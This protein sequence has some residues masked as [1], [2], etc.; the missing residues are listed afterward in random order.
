MNVFTLSWRNMWRN[1][2][3]TLITIA[4]VS[5]A[6]FFA[7]IMRAFQEG[8]YDRAI[9]NYVHS[10]SGHVQIHA[11]GYWDEQILEHSFVMNDSLLSVIEAIPEVEKIIPRLHSFT[12][13]S[14]EYLTKAALVMGVNPEQDDMQSNISNN[15]IF[16]SFVSASDTAVLVSEGLAEYLT[17]VR[18]D[19][20]FSE[21]KNGT[22][23]L[24]SLRMVKD[25][26]VLI[27]QGMYGYST[28]GVYPVQGI[29]SYP[30][31]EMNSQVI[32]MPLQLAQNFFLA[33]NRVTSISLI[34]S[35][36]EHLNRIQQYLQ[37]TLDMDVYEVMSW[38]EMNIE[39]VQ[40]IETDRAGGY[41]M[42]F[43]L[44]LIIGFGIFGTVVMMT[45]ERKR[46]FGIIVALGMRKTRLMYRFCV[47]MVYMGLIGVV[48]GCISAL[49]VLLY[50]YY[51]P[52]RFSGEL[53]QMMK[54]YGFEP[55][56]PV[57]FDMSLFVDHG[58]IVLVLFFV[59]ALYTLG[60]IRKLEVIQAIR[61]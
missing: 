4:S 35:D 30:D 33:Q 23:T 45:A 7:L 52:V 36:K 42:I 5:S 27:S 43:I 20:T 57:S 48:G 22:D 40:Q 44:Y 55:I 8:T 12:F 32:Y 50:F 61:N 28:N 60:T 18:R 10:F 54:N 34:L 26:I 19:T 47:E 59:S 16:G 29:I 13:A 15:V 46:E 51:N 31:P 41:V 2:R 14:S 6:L 3:R 25:S 58:L 39:L 38:Q 49:P 37:D 1:K 56:L 21:T 53:A 17:I 24:I 9:Y 11:N